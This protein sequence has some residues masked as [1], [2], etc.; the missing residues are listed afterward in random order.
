MDQP[1][2]QRPHPGDRA[3]RAWPQ[4]VPLH[5]RWR[6]I[7]DR[8]KYYRMGPFGRGLPNLCRRTD[9]DLNRPGLPREK[10]LAAVLRLMDETLIRIGNEEYARQ[11]Q[12]YSLTT[13]RHEHLRT[14]FRAKSGKQQRVQLSDPRLAEIV[15]PAMNCP[16][17][18]CSSTSARPAR[19]ATLGHGREEEDRRGHRRRRGAA[20]QYAGGMP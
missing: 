18:S 1:G 7:R 11:D 12:S 19:C 16:A 17:R 4:A 15:T 10:V 8:T 9:A 6:E 5:P 2:T 14:E 20:E 3:R 13:L